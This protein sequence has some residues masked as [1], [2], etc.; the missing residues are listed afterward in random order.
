MSDDALIVLLL[1]L[2]VRT[3]LYVV[4]LSTKSLSVL[5]MIKKLAIFAQARHVASVSNKTLCNIFCVCK[6]NVKILYKCAKCQSGNYYS[7]AYQIKQ[8]PEH[9]K[10]CA[11][12]SEL[13]SREKHKLEQLTVTGSEILPRRC[14]SQLVRLIVEKPIIEGYIN[15]KTYKGLWDTGSMVSVLNK[16]WLKS[17]FPNEKN[18]SSEEFW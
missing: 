4:L 13:D 6:K 17:N 1:N 12:I 11:V 9:K 15:N 5:T 2:V 8:Y 10:Y 18:F 14:R 16:H 7:K 3:V